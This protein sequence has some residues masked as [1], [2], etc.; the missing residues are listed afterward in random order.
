[1]NDTP[2]PAMTMAD[3]AYRRNA[4]EHAVRTAAPY[5]QPRQVLTAAAMFE[6][7][8]R[9]GTTTPPPPPAR[10]LPAGLI[11]LASNAP[12]LRLDIVTAVLKERERQEASGWTADHDDGH[13]GGEIANEAAGVIM[14]PETLANAAGFPFV[15]WVPPQ[16]NRQR[17]LVK[18]IALAVAELERLGRISEAGLV[19]FMTGRPTGEDTRTH[20]SDSALDDDDQVQPVNL[21]PALEALAA[22]LTEDDLDNMHHAIGRPADV[23]QRTHRNYFATDDDS[24]EAKR[25][26]ELRAFWTE[27]EPTAP[28]QG[29]RYFHIT[30][31]GR[32]ALGVAIEANPKAFRV[33]LR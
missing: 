33:E 23:W 8:L 32:A 11:D 10:P 2:R 24:A 4:L 12:A 14:P 16:P 17:A 31:A 9:D 21:D 15:G 18:G 7:Y 6:A 3:V 1:M 30:A 25:F 13:T 28:T 5:S 27:T 22:T 19:D 20:G 26:R 29:M